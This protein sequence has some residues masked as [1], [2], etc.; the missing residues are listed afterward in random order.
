MLACMSLVT[1]FLVLAG[2]TVSRLQRT[3][4]QISVN[5]VDLAAIRRLSPLAST[6]ATT[7]ISVS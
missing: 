3:V 4:V 7:H 2:G 6:I 1:A 5:D